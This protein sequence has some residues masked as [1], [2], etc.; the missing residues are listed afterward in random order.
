MLDLW[1][2]WSSPINNPVGY[3]ESL[4]AGVQYTMIANDQ[5]LAV[6]KQS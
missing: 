3:A 1:A 5:G 6:M 4:H 2:G